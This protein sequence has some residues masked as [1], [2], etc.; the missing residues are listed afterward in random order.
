M[1][2]DNILHFIGVEK[3]NNNL[4]LELWLI[5]T[6]HDKVKALTVATMALGL[7]DLLVCFQLS[8][9][10]FL[11]PTTTIR[12]IV[13]KSELFEETWALNSVQTSAKPARFI[14]VCC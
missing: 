11:E 9:V 1:K 2:H 13:P 10:C 7:N 5:T 12:H 14:D 4:D 6:Y 3:R 8:S